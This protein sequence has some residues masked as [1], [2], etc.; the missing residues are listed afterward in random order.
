MVRCASCG[1]FHRA[2]CFCRY[3]KRHIAV[4]EIHKEIPCNGYYP[5]SF[6]R[7]HKILRQKTV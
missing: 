1:N 3:Y 4:K 6:K 7:N 5:F 2:S